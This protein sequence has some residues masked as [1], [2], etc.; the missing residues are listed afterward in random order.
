MSTLKYEILIF[1]FLNVMLGIQP[2]CRRSTVSPR[3][4]EAGVAG[5]LHHEDD[6]HKPTQVN[7]RDY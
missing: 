7:A 4:T 6:A 2:L 5:V 3:T 1:F